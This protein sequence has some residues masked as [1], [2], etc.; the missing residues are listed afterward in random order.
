MKEKLIRRKY[1]STKERNRA[2]KSRTDWERLRRMKDEDI[3]YSDIPPATKEFWE[4]AILVPAGK[5]AVSM[6]IDDVIVDWFKSQG[7]G[8]QTRM[9][10]VLRA[11]IEHQTRKKRSASR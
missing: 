11:Y 5:I 3:D 6:R 8:Y 2:T 4:N 7:R 1:E 9:N 10:R